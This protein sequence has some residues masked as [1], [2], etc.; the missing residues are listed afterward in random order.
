MF[1]E[2]PSA[3]ALPVCPPQHGNRG[4]ITVVYSCLCQCE[5]H[6]LCPPWLSRTPCY[7]RLWTSHSHGLGSRSRH[8]AANWMKQ[9]EDIVCCPLRTRVS[10]SRDQD[11]G[12]VE[13][14][15]VL[16]SN[17]ATG[18]ELWT[19]LYHCVWLCVWPAAGFCKRR[20]CLLLSRGERYVLTWNTR[21]VCSEN[22]QVLDV[23]RC[24]E[25]KH[26]LNL[27]LVQTV[28]ICTQKQGYWRKCDK[29]EHIVLIHS[30]TQQS[31]SKN[32]CR[33]FNQAQVLQQSLPAMH[34]KEQLNTSAVFY[35]L[36]KTD[37]MIAA[38]FKFQSYKIS[39][40]WSQ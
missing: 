32:C 5:P 23:R 11:K 37:K 24:C 2:L 12:G 36:L 8:A 30:L 6:L 18:Y 4:H 21:Q 20:K 17:N 22:T 39:S 10:Q 35:C 14:L 27:W 13:L 9:A 40:N 15:T 19:Q 38:V 26:V 28:F 1:L 33:N 34:C 7:W 16:I 3:A 25:G 29:H 31:F